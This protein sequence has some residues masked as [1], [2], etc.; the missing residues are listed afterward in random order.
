LDVF[1]GEVDPGLHSSQQLK[2]GFSIG[3]E[4]TAQFSSKSTLS[5]ENRTFRPSMDD[6]ENCFRLCQVDPAVEKSAFGKFA[7]A[8]GSSPQRA[9]GLKD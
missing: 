2:E 3:H 5:R 1:L 8:G 9:D 7:W 4:L 6:I